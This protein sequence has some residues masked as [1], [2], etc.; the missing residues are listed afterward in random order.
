MSAKSSRVSSTLPEFR[1]SNLVRPDVVGL[2]HIEGQPAGILANQG[3]LFSESALKAAHFIEQRQ[4]GVPLVFQNITASWSAHR[5]GGTPDGAKMVMAGECR[6]SEVHGGDRRLF[7]AGITA[8]AVVRIRRGNCGWAECAHLGDGR[9]T[10][11]NGL[12]TV[13]SLQL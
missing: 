9:R 5:G 1:E 13:K 11:A 2:A 12:L 8:C 6:S 7:G 10:G 3:I 4:A